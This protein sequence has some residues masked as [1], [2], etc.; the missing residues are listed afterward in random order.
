MRHWRILIAAL[1]CF[2]PALQYGLMVHDETLATGLV[3]SVEFF[4]YFT[5]LSN[6]LAAVVLTAPLVAPNSKVAVWAER[7]ATRISVA[8]YL[9][10][11]AGIYHTLLAGL[12]DPKGWRLVSDII[13]HSITPAAF[14]ID[15]LLRGGQG[16]T[17]RATAA[18]ALIFPALYGVWTLGHGATSGFYPYPFFDVAKHGYLS[19][20]VTMLVLA[21]GFL[22]IALLFTMIHQ[23]RT[24]LATGRGTPL[25][26]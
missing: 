8:V 21:G 17:G 11:T 24:R 13:L 14:V 5:I 3:K 6:L 7:S 19:V 10:L 23:A 1:A 15:W 4:S 9:S 2:G 18:K 22:L 12:W 20:F 26:A 16:E 25:S